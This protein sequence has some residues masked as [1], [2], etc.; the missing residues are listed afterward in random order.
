MLWVLVPASSGQPCMI[1][2]AKQT[3][4]PWL[5]KCAFYL[6]KLKK[7]NNLAIRRFI[8]HP[9]PPTPSTHTPTHTQITHYSLC[10][11]SSFIFVNSEEYNIHSTTHFISNHQYAYGWK[12][13]YFIWHC[14]IQNILAWHWAGKSLSKPAIVPFTYAYMHHPAIHWY[15]IF[16]KSI[17]NKWRLCYIFS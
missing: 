4:D 14:T 1:S 3:A 7:Q 10:I 6:R 11:Q 9:H 5:D 13:I 15:N 16:R 12:H 17:T 2:T 8:R